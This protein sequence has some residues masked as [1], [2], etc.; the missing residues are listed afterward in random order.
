M[1]LLTPE[2]T[3]G[4]VEVGDA[5]GW[6]VRE[7]AVALL[8]TAALLPNGFKHRTES[9]TRGLEADIPEGVGIVGRARGAFNVNP[10]A[11]CGL[12]DNRY[13]FYVAVVRSSQKG[14]DGSRPGERQSDAWLEGAA[15]LFNGNRPNLALPS[16][17]C[18]IS[19]AVVDNDPRFLPAWL[20]QL[21][22]VYLLVNV[23]VREVMPRA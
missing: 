17:C 11:P 5:T 21:D 12:V 4:N 15:R 6:S 18:V 2:L 1:P 7:G 16:G 22:A 13:S 23:V 20:K 19:S 8:N 14:L 10:Q 3:T 9:S